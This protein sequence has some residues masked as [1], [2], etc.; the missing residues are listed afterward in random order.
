[1]DQLAARIHKEIQ[2]RIPFDVRNETRTFC[3]FPIRSICGMKVHIELSFESLGLKRKQCTMRINTFDVLYSENSETQLFSYTFD[4][5]DPATNFTI[6]TEEKIIDYIKQMLDIIPTLRLD[7]L[8]ACLTQREPMDTSYFELF[9]FDNTELKYDI[10]SVCHEL[11]GTKTKCKHTI[12]IECASK[13]D[14][15][16]SDEDED[17]EYDCPLCRAKFKYICRN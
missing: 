16:Q 7:K 2:D 1:M 4:S 13:L 12:C 15:Y 8:K 10:C 14:G 9:K 5:I 17:P 6:F 3:D 11:C